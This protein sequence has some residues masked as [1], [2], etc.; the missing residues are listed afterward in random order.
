MKKSG[1]FIVA[2]LLLLADKYANCHVDITVDVKTK[3]SNKFWDYEHLGCA[4]GRYDSY[5]YNL[6]DG[7]RCYKVTYGD[8]VIWKSVGNERALRVIL[9]GRGIA[10][11]MVEIDLDNDQGTSSVDCNLFKVRTEDTSESSGYKDND[12]SKYTHELKGLLKNQ[13]LYKFNTGTKF[14][15]LL[16][17]DEFVWQHTSSHDS[18]KFPTELE[19]DPF[20]N[21]LWIKY[22]GMD[23]LTFKFEN[24]K[25]KHSEDLSYGDCKRVKIPDYNATSEPSTPEA[26]PAEVKEGEE[27]AEKPEEEAKPEKAEDESEEKSAEESTEVDT[28]DG[29]GKTED[30]EPVKPEEGAPEVE[31]SEKHPKEAEEKTEDASKA[32]GDDA[33]ATV[34]TTPDV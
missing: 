4:Y 28:G 14:V 8:N 11:K 5:L 6:K 13:P 33:S 30:A 25:W 15:A 22:G 16:Y 32:E 18:S 29:E 20:N 31:E 34:D 26:T 17:N 23:F 10:K 21:T 19:I 27:E 7:Y 2:F 3:W 1:Y 12:T 24:N 9:S